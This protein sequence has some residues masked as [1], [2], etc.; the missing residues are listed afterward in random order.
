MKNTN[1]ETERAKIDALVAN[2]KNHG[3]HVEMVAFPAH[4]S[5]GQLYADPMFVTSRETYA[6]RLVLIDNKHSIVRA[7]LPSWY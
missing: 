6:C 3:Q 1:H 4:A 5:D 2:A 7:M